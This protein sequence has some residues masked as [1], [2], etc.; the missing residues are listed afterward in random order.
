MQPRDAVRKAVGTGTCE[1]RHIKAGAAHTK[2]V[3]EGPGLGG[4]M[5]SVSGIADALW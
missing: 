5:W 4:G 1:E 3:G 2:G